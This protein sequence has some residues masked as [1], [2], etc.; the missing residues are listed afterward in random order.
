MTKI[1]LA[2]DERNL[3]RILGYE[4]EAAGYKVDLAEDGVDYI[5]AI[6]GK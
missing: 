1:L 4:L 3:A 6:E 5:G 2:E